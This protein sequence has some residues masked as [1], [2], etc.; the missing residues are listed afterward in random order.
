[1]IRQQ[2]DN[3]PWYKQF[4]PWF[5]L[6]LPASVVVAGIAT[7]IIAFQNQDSLVNDDYYKEGLAINQKLQQQQQARQ[8]QLS[9][10]ALINLNQQEITVDLDGNTQAV[11]SAALVVDFIH[12]VNSKLDFQLTLAQVEDGQYQALLPE[13]TSE[14]W[15]LQISPAN[16][17]DRINW[18]LR[19]TANLSDSAAVQFHSNSRG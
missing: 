16:P 7:V 15:H 8:W 11:Y 19:S 14:R 10:Q 13:L 1:M 17:S 5:I 4:W 6:I 3:T 2:L 12:P 9:A 18:R